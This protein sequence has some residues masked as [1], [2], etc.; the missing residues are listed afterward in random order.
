MRALMLALL[1]STLLAC[2]GPATVILVR[3]A[4][5]TD[6]QDDPRLSEAGKARAAELART[7]A[8]ARLTTILTTKTMRSKE[9]ADPVAETLNLTPEVVPIDDQFAADMA[10]R[11]R[12]GYRDRAVLIIADAGQINQLAKAFGIATGAKIDR[13]AHDDLLF[14]QYDGEVGQLV[15]G[16]YGSAERAAVA[17]GPQVQI[18][19]IVVGT[20]PSPEKGQT[21]VVHYTGRLQNGTKFDSS[22]DHGKPFEFPYGRGKVIKGWE[23][24]LKTMK[25]GGKRRLT[26]PPELA[27][28]S[29]G[30]GGVIPPDATLVFEVELLAI[31]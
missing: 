6:D 24:G 31:K 16:R 8:D 13:G 14:I 19:E 9:T 11:I 27:Y 29:K 21:V 18:E 15:R 25:V 12:M 7:L 1:G 4:E 26:I 2:G 22:H 10:R 17:S 3:H 23:Q 5:I 28:G 30:A 20:G